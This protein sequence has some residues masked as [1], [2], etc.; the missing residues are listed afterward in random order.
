MYVLAL[1]QGTTSCRAILFDQSGSI[2]AS[3]AHEITQYYPHPGWVEHDANEIW[4]KQVRAFRGVVGRAGIRTEEIAAIGITNQ[5]ETTVIWDRASGRPVCPAIVWQSRQTAPICDE[6]KARGFEA[7]FRERTGLLL[8]PYFSGTKIKWILDNVDGVRERAERGDLAF[9][10][11]DSWLVYKLTGG[12]VHATEYS[13]ASRT[14][15]YN[16]HDLRWDPELLDALDIPATLLPE[17]RESSGVFGEIAD[18]LLDGARI[19]ISGVAGDQQAALFGQTC[20]DE[21]A[22]KNTY[23]T[24]C[25]M[26]MNTG[27]KPHRSESGL[28]TTIAW[29]VDG[30]IVYALE[31][32]V[33]VAGAAVQWLRDE[34]GLISNVAET[35][36]IVS[37][38]DDTGG[39]YLVPAF[40]GLGAPYWDSEARGTL[41]G[42]TRGSGRSHLVRAVL[43]SIAY[44]TADVLRCF[45]RDTGLKILQLQ[46]DGG[47][48]ANDFLMQF[49]ADILGIPV[50]R[51][52]VLE[53][54]ALG[55]AYLAGLAVGFWEGRDQIRRN[56]QED[57][58]FEPEMEAARREELYAGWLRAVERCRS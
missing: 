7:L 17:V 48:A 6:L 14:L 2:V 46:V 18:D 5:R 11:I 22:V 1:D 36:A 39:V 30:T 16:L 42:L 28:L 52:V 53:T 13:N 34:L 10:T 58:C 20:F 31:G 15:I 55:A 3:Q 56:W 41:V 19:P 44:Q 45:E 37:S 26:L 23:G 9:G 49:Q 40:T 54:T 57:R 33:F 38:I 27:T 4:D 50:R 29:G 32:S 24:G 35:E 47:A 51:P 21:G 12:K 43:E 8:D 25:F